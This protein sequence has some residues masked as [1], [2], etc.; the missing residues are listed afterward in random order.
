MLT[1]P[2]QA[3]YAT[4]QSLIVV[5][6]LLVAA[7]CYLLLGRMA[8]AVLPDNHQKLF[9]LSPTKITKIFVGI[10]IVS[11]LVQASGSG[12]ASS[13][14]WEG[15]T[16]EVGVNVLIAGLA[17]QLAT[18]IVFLFLLWVFSD[19]AY[20]G[21]HTREGAPK[22]WERAFE[23]VAISTTLITVGLKWALEHSSIATDR[24]V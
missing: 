6:P 9:G 15:N 1:S 4:S 11:F 23:A 2:R 17:T 8:L 12:I 13:N 22:K 3:L 16:K 20:F 14:N 24:Y 18:I 5:A 21:C 10:D 19:K 7:G